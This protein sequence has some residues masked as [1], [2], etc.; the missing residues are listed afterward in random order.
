MNMK[1]EIF[2]DG[3]SPFRISSLGFSFDANATR[4]GPGQ[5]DTYIVHYVTKGKGY[6]N[7]NPVGKGQG[8]LIYPHQHQE[9][10]SDKDD[11]WEFL[12]MVAGDEIMEVIFRQYNADSNTLIF[13]YNSVSTVESVAGELKLRNNKIVN[14]SEIMELYLHILNS[15]SYRNTVA[16]EKSNAQTY[17][18]FCRNYIKSHIYEPI[19]VKKLTELLGVSQPYLYKIFSRTFHMSIK[20][21]ITMCKIEYAKNLLSKTDMS[22]T[23]I[24][25]SIGYPDVLAFSKM[26]SSREG[27]SPA[28]YRL[29]LD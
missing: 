23:E 22:I 11:P 7:G 15:H 16:D 24:A 17:L 9:Y 25:N 8:F 1:Y 2:S 26:F 13:N 14:S 6:Y 3:S 27:I 4:F 28:K 5:R 29:N 18:E 21:Y 19:S 10:F 12:W 20:D